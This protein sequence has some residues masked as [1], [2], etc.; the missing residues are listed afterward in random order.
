MKLCILGAGPAGISSALYAKR[1]NIDTTIFYKEDSTLSK[2]HLID[3]YYGMPNVQGEDLYKIGIEQAREIGVELIKEEV[4]AI[5]FGERFEVI[6][7]SNTKIECDAIIIA[8][9]SY[10]NVPTIRNIKNYE[11]KGVSYC[12]ACDGFFYRGK[13]LAVLG[14][15]SYAKHEADY[16]KNL[17][18]DVTILTNGK[19]IED[20]GLREF[21]VIEDKIISIEGELK[22][23]KF[24]LASKEEFACDGLFIALG[25]AGSVDFAK[26]LGIQT[27]NNKIVVDENMR[28]NIEGIYACGDCTPGMLQ[29]SKAVYEGALAGSDVIKLFNQKKKEQKNKQA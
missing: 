27:E 9:G 12:A 22:L 8:T 6:G 7:H 23:E 1:A 16:L 17:T 20:E 4:V 5:Q 25:S 15:G 11:G 10:R 14:T 28:T 13:K 19:E 2:G 24:I 29:I 21:N 18:D 26:K 3:N